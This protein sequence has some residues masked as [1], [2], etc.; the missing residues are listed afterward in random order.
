[1]RIVVAASDPGFGNWMSTDGHRFGAIGLRWNQATEDVEPD[2][3][4]IASAAP[5]SA[6]SQGGFSLY[7]TGFST[8]NRTLSVQ[9]LEG[10]PH[11]GHE[12]LGLLEGGEVAAHLG[13][14]PVPD[15]GV[16][17]L[18]PAPAGPEDLVGED[19]AR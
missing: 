3:R 8:E 9:E 13:L 7:T 10:G 1:M 18:S 11:L 17:L 6:D 14:V 5:T 2:V 19:A 15:V 4:V 16:A 12:Q